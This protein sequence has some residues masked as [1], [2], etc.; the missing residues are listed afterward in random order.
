MELSIIDTVDAQQRQVLQLVGSLDL[1]SRD[2]LL[3]AAGAALSAPLLA[4]LVLNLAGVTFLDSSGIGAVVQIAGDA[5]DAGVAFGLQALSDRVTHV[6][7]TAGMLDAWPVE[8]AP[9]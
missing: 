6:L 1:A 7:E 9:A 4:G 3:Q 2:Q 8:A 5:E